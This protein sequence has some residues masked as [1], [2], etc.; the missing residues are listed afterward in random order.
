LGGE[1]MFTGIIQSVG[2]IRN[3]ERRGTDC[4]YTVDFA[5]LDKHQISIGDSIAVSGVCLTAVKLEGSSFRADVSVETLSCTTFSSIVPATRVN[6]ELALTPATRMGGHIV[7]GHVDGIG[8][9]KEKTSVGRSV[10][11]RIAVPDDLAKY[12][13]AK[14]S[15]CV[16]GISLT[17]NKVE[18]SQFDVNI[19]PHTLHATTLGAA[20]AGHKVNIEVDMLARYLER[21]LSRSDSLESDAS[22]S[23]AKLNE[24]GFFESGGA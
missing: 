10:Q 6:L 22:L 12:I 2:T 17:V 1:L 4:R 24:A 20:M 15:V 3:I 7:S 11:Y 14:G 19:V 23:I 16:D 21:L 8:V 5:G 13:A 18:G 9:I